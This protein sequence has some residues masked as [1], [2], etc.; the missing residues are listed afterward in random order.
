MI[1]FA[2]AIAAAAARWPVAHGPPALPGAMLASAT[3]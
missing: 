3:T 2:R 1:L